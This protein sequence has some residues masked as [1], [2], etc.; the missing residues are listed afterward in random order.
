MQY[1]LLYMLFCNKRELNPETWPVINLETIYVILI[2]ISIAIS[3][4]F[5]M[6]KIKIIYHKYKGE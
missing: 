4:V 5:L 6:H 1:I 2:Q 3:I